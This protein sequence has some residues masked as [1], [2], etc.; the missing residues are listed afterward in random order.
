MSNAATNFDI[1]AISLSVL[2]NYFASS[3]KFS[4]LYPAKILDLSGKLFFP[5]INIVKTDNLKFRQKIFSIFSRRLTTS[6]IK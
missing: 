4:D 1:S 2:H 6:L 5:C 3:T